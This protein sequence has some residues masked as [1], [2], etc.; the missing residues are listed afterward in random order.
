VESLKTILVSAGEA[1]GDRYAT[2]LVEELRR[3]HPEAQFFGCAGARLRE[4]G[5]EAVVRG[6]SLS[7]VGLVEVIHHIPRI[8]Q[9]F[10]RLVQAA[11]TRRPDLAILTDSPD[12]HFRV[13]GKLREMGVPVVYLVAPQVWAWRQGRTKVMRRIIDRLLCIFPFEE[14]FFVDRGVP[15]VY[16]GHPLAGRVRPSLSKVEFFRKHSLPHDRPLIAILPGSRQGEAARHLPVLMEVA[17][18]LQRE[19]GPRA[20][21]RLRQQRASSSSGNVWAR[22]R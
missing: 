11:R 13:A 19:D 21:C 12:F 6:E 22:R 18:R 16:I 4:A 7:V 1:S 10:R 5:V 9:E 15:A 2:L 3:R 8:Y 20:F 14:K 17:G